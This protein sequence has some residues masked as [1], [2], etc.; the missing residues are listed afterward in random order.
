MN[1]RRPLPIP[2]KLVQ[3]AL[4]RSVW[5]TTIAGRHDGTEFVA[6]VWTGFDAPSKIVFALAF[7]EEGVHALCIGVP[8]VDD[9][10]A[11]GLPSKS[12]TTPC[13][14]STSPLSVPS[15]RRAL[16]FDNGAFAT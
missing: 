9:G 15:S 4:G 10:A 11:T 3:K 7:V 8:Y 12:R 5:R 16:P 1:V 6:A 2:T 14:N 13:M